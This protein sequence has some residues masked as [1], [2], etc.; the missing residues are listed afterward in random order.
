MGDTPTPREAQLL[1]EVGSIYDKVRALRVKDAGRN[2]P[3]IEGVETESR[4]KWEQLRSLR[5]GPATGEPLP[6]ENR[7]ALYNS[8]YRLPM[9]ELRVLEACSFFLSDDGCAGSIPTGGDA[10]RPR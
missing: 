3:Q 7:R 5:A 6:P 8:T 2:G 4:L 1:R 9:P 10:S